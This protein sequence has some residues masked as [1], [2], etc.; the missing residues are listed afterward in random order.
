MHIASH[1]S[2]VTCGRDGDAAA[3]QRSYSSPRTTPIFFGGSVEIRAKF[4]A[5]DDDRLDALQGGGPR[6]LLKRRVDDEQLRLRVVADLGDLGDRGAG[7]H[8]HG[9]HSHLAEAGDD[10]RKLDA[11]RGENGGVGAGL[12]ARPDRRR[13]RDPVNALHQVAE[14]EGPLVLAQRHLV[15]APAG[16]R[17]QPG[18][19]GEGTVGGRSPEVPGLGGRRRNRRG[20]YMGAHLGLVS[21]SA[22]SC[23]VM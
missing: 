3:S 7:A 9:R 22:T 10:L 2:T 20:G 8:R 11:V 15:G 19:E 12:K 18:A 14:A 23:S 5:E 16:R 4:D 6:R 1:S 13:G 17:P 21:S